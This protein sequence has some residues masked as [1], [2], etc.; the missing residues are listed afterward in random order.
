MVQNDEPGAALEEQTKTRLLRGRDDFRHVVEHDD[1]GGGEVG[2]FPT[3]G[4]AVGVRD[5]GENDFGVVAKN[6]E[7]GLLRETVAAGEDE[8]AD[9]CRRFGGDGGGGDDPRE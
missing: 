8:G 6:P 1:I 7:E 5:R 9:F 3:V 4:R 2:A